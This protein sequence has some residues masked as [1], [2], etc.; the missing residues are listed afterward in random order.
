MIVDF[1]EVLLGALGDLLV[2][3]SMHSHNGVVKVRYINLVS[4]WLLTDS[5]IISRLPFLL[6]LL[7]TLLS[8]GTIAHALQPNILS[9]LASV[10]RR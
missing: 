5:H 4:H 2:V 8:L 1:F 3:S 10:H 9:S 7:T 6:P